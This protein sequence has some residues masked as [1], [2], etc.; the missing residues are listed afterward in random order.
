VTSP[1]A[2]YDLIAYPAPFAYD[3][4][5]NSTAFVLPKD[6]INS[7]REAFHVA[8]YL[9]D[10]SNGPVTTLSVFFADQLPETV[11]SKYNFIVVGRPSQLPILSEIN[12]YLPAPFDF[13]KDVAAEPDMQVKYR[14]NPK[15]DVG[16]VE[17]L[18]SPWN[19]DNV[20]L[21]A[22]G[23]DAKGVSWAASH[24]IEPLSYKLSGNFAVINDKQVYSVDT[25]LTMLT[26]GIA[27]TQAPVLEVVPPAASNPGASA[28]YRPSWILPALIFSVLLILLTIVVVIYINWFRNRS[29]T[30]KL[31]V[32]D[33]KQE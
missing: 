19:G 22:V 24:L 11:R 28:P 8:G 31:V 1:T 30:S 2:N 4:T 9:G 25:R 13:G 27:A 26:P 6:D 16:Y 33:K 15:A 23:N 10:R 12:K 29:D 7:W 3:A 17:L 5:L 18:S 14:L 20:I 32:P 21:T